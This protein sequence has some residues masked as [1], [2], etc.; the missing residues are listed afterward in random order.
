[1]VLQKITLMEAYMIETLRLKGITD[2]EILDKAFNGNVGE[3]EIL[4]P[5][6][7]FQQLAQLARRDESVFRS[8]VHDGYAVKFV[9]I[10]GL[11]KLLRLKFGKHPDKDYT[12]T[13]NGITGLSVDRDELNALKRVL[14]GNWSIV[15]ISTAT[16]QDVIKIQAAN[17]T[18]RTEEYVEV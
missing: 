11:T 9:T 18:Y 3:W 8:A 4:A 2:E 7:D 15:T 6:Y 14:S 12:L 13:A 17:D 10:K 16:D 5:E 1:M